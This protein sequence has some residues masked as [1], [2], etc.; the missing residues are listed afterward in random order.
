[1]FIDTRGKLDV[2]YIINM[3]N[4]I[5]TL[6]ILEQWKSLAAKAMNVNV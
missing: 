1:M 4:L 3:T 5:K 2:N 6:Y